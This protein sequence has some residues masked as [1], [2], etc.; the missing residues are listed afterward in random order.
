MFS[1]SWLKHEVSGAQPQSRADRALVRRVMSVGSDHDDPVEAREQR[2]PFWIGARLGLCKL[3]GERVGG[4]HRQ[5]GMSQRVDRPQL[6]ATAQHDLPMITF[7]SE[8]RAAARVA[9]SPAGDGMI[10]IDRHRLHNQLGARLVEG[11][12]QEV[13]HGVLIRTREC[14]PGET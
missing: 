6:I 1:C 3:A 13:A 2:K 12:M 4:R 14:G 8:Q 10:A 7:A 9:M 11:R 5:S